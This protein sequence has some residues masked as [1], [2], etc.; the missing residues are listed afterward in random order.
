MRVILPLTMPRRKL[1]VKDLGGTACSSVVFSV[2]D[3]QFQEI[4]R[5]ATKH[6]LAIVVAWGATPEDDG[7]GGGCRW[8]DAS[9]AFGGSLLGTGETERLNA[10]QI[11][12]FAGLAVPGDEED[13]AP[14]ASMEAQRA[15]MYRAM[16]AEIEETVRQFEQAGAEPAIVVTRSREPT[17]EAA[18]LSVLGSRVASG[19]TS[20]DAVELVR[21]LTSGPGPEPRS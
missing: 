8:Y 9:T 18:L 17:L 10:K 14:A 11:A 19:M 2:Q 4:A 20:E 1:Y 16:A 15:G 7:R 21:K 12:K 6:G 3:G 13:G 5:V